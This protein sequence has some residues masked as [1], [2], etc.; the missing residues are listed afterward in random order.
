MRLIPLLLSLLLIP[1]LLAAQSRTLT[2][3][4][5]Q[6]LEPVAFATLIYPE[7]GRGQ[8]AD[9]QGKIA[10]SPN[11]ED[12]LIISGLGYRPRLFS[13]LSLPDTVWLSPRHAQWE[14]LTLTPAYEKIRRLIHMAIAHKP[15]NNPEEYPAYQC[16]IYYKMTM[17]GALPSDTLLD[18]NTQS[19][20]EDFL[21]ENDLLVTESYTHR[22]YQK[23][24]RTQETVL[25]S[26]ISG[27]KKSPF[28]HLITEVLPFHAYDDFIVLNGKAYGNPLA[29]GWEKRYEFS[30]A[31][32]WTEG[33]DS[34]FVLPFWPK[35]AYRNQGLRGQLVICSRGYAIT[36][37]EASSA[38]TGQGLTRSLRQVYESVN[39]RW[40]PRTLEYRLSL[41]AKKT[42]RVLLELK[43][44]AHIDSVEFV[45]AD[46]FKFQAAYPVQLHENRDSRTEAEWAQ[47]RPLPL[48]PR[49]EKTLSTLDSLFDSQGLEPALWALGKAISR[50]LWPIGPLDIDLYRLG[51]FN[52]LESIRAGMGLYTNEK[53]SSY[54]SLGGWA[55]YGVRDQVA[56]Y[57]AD[58]R[59]YPR[60]HPDHRLHLYYSRD[61]RQKGHRFRHPELQS[62]LLSTFLFF[63]V[64]EVEGLGAEAQWRLGYFDLGGAAV[65][66]TI[67][68]GPPYVFEAP[69]GRRR[70]GREKRPAWIFDMPSGKCAF[71]HS[72]NTCPGN[73][74]TP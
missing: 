66:E 73:P 11:P 51:T 54:F 67:G 30:L 14:E 27:F 32:Q 5:T 35:K 1:G 17:Q 63:L 69:Q 6:S 23:P 44:F 58:L 13:A 22:I 33:A 47:F 55:G 19:S 34:F 16:R 42:S 71:R 60:G 18:K 36:R 25:A 61:Y 74:N 21:G 29:K 41:Q 12:S 59:I 72:A 37:L 68:P 57:G 28:A 26:R 49:E 70:P 43:G 10:L 15:R 9:I 46:S 62:R 31:E 53:I 2:V 50:G 20:L 65:R 24:G 3:I 7:S 40:F 4:D 52:R 8:M 48:S 45:L 39:G 56:K 64:D 38:D